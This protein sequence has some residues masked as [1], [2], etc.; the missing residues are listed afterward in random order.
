MLTDSHA[1]LDFAAYQEDREEVIQRCQAKGMR[2]IN[3]GSQLATSALAVKLSQDYEWMYAAIGQHPIHAFDDLPAPRPNKYFVYA[4][5][6]DD[7][8]IYIG[9]ARDIRKAWRLH[10]DGNG[11]EH[12]KK[13]K[14]LYI[15]HYEEFNSR[16]DAVAREK[17]FKTGL[18]QKW[19]KQEFNAGRTRQTG[20]FN[21]LAYQALI[22]N[23]KRIVAI[24][25][26]GYD[27][28]YIKEEGKTLAE[29]KDKQ[30][31]LFVKQIK[32]AQANDL[33]LMIHGRNGKDG[34]NAYVDILATLKEYDCHRGQVHC[35]GGSWEEA[36]AFIKQGFYIGIT[37]IVTFEKKAEELQNIAKQVPLDR[38]LIETDSPYLTPVPH[39]GQRNEPAFVE[40]VA[41]RIAT[42]R[43]ISYD[44]V[45]VATSANAAKLYNL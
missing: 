7:E 11:A 38:L 37:G 15:I 10:R 31:E 21:S 20:E 23:N 40:W 43:G 9:Q 33:P 16:I 17:K 32:L 29:L 41:R 44:E 35:F 45:V 25:E 26:C 39:R 3:V 8:S 18:G 27:Y 42:L 12:T 24:G 14:P 6:C 34:E 4:I 19:L 1:H 13:H 28:F 36:Q 22:D 5:L 30:T 2:V